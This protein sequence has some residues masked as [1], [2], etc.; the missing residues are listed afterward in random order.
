M[1]KERAIRQI[2]VNLDMLQDFMEKEELDKFD[3]QLMRGYAQRVSEYIGW[4]YL[5]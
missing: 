2:K 3:L 5:E 4:L 1:T